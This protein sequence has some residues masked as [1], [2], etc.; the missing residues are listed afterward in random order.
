MLLSVFIKF[1][2]TGELHDLYPSVSIILIKSSIVKWAGHVACVVEKNAHRV[3]V[4]KT[5][6]E[7]MLG[8]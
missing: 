2:N 6:G 1:H 5:E 7:R 8:A 3:L 4:M